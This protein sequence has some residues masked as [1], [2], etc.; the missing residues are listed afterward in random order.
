AWYSWKFMWDPCVGGVGM[1]PVVRT[2][3]G[4]R[5]AHAARG[6]PAILADAAGAGKRRRVPAPAGA[7]SRRAYTRPNA[8]PATQLAFHFC[9]ARLHPARPAA[10]AVPVL[11]LPPAGSEPAGADGIRPRRGA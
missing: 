1:R 11:A 10:R 6:R 4:R 5:A 8:Q 9:P 3:P 7:G 2:D